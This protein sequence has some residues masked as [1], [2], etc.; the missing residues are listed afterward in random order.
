MDVNL[1]GIHIEKIK[2]YLVFFCFVFLFNCKSVIDE[3]ALQ[4]VYHENRAVAIS[5][6]GT[7]QNGGYSISLKENP[8]VAVLG[9]FSFENGICTFSPIVPFSQGEIYGLYRENQIVE[10]FQIKELS[11]KLP[12]LITI[13]PTKDTVPENLLKV[14]FQFS[15]PMQEVGDPLDYIK[16]MNI[17]DAREE[18]VF[19]ELE[20][21]LWNLEHTRLTLWLDPGR[22]KTDLIPNKEKGLPI[23]KGKEYE[24][25]ISSKW[26]AAN[27]Q[28]LKKDYIKT[29]Y[30][31]GKDT[32]RPL[33]SNWKVHSPSEGTKE[34]LKIDFKESMDGVLS[35]EVFTIFLNEGD[36][37]IEGDFSVIPKE[38][39]VSFS[40][41]NKWK[42]GSYTIYVDSRFEDLAGNNLNHVFDR[43]ITVKEVVEKPSE[44]KT[45][46]FTID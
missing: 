46:V 43:D 18:S 27:G 35:K 8:K 26:R 30:V 36:I 10:T 24:V 16:V 13:Y 19:L 21:R 15:E 44:T 29:I 33:V 45:I 28:Y 32:H 7:E 3:T 39:G 25:H 22:I 31:T 23:S 9:S 2:F 38:H 40:P 14:Y 5:F 1:L 4:V 42:K 17:T 34:L 37:P 11:S 41:H 12:E 6:K 20:A